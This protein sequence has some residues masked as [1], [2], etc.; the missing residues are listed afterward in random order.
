L[1]LHKQAVDAVAATHFST[2]TCH[3]GLT[4]GVPISNS[5]ASRHL[6]ELVQYAKPKGVTI[7]LENL[8]KAPT[9]D[10][11]MLERWVRDSGAATTL[12]LGH[13]LSCRNY[14][15]KQAA[16][17]DFIDRM[18]DRLIE[19]HF[20]EKE[21]DRH[22]A[23]ENMEVLG[24]ILD[25]LLQTACRWWTIELDDVNELQQTR[26]MVWEYLATARRNAM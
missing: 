20:Y 6:G 4:R 14:L 21:T 16:I 26:A 22:Y 15:D 24:P 19:V 9:S 7:A 3:I 18:G 13:A 12:D 8:K 17:F 11:R 25:R 5:I 1:K 10:L 23:P 2:I